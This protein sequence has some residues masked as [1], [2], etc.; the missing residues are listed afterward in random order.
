MEKFTNDI[1]SIYDII[2]E[3]I[4]KRGSKYCLVSKKSGRNLG[5]YPSKSGAKKR[6]KQAFK[7]ETNR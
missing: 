7:I 4:V 2:N 1:Y 3:H 6:E 5:C